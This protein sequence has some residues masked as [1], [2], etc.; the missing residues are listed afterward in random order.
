M[1]LMFAEPDASVVVEMD[2]CSHTVFITS[3]IESFML[4]V[5]HESYRIDD[6]ARGWKD[7]MYKV[8]G[9]G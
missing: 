7:P 4:E 6:C 2:G 5:R 8:H 1:N 9:Q 3:I